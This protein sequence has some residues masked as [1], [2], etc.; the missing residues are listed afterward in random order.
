MVELFV[1]PNSSKNCI[2]DWTFKRIQAF[3]YL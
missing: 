1:L 2:I 3:M